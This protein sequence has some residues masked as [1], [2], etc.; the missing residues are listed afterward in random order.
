MTDISVNSG[1]C[2]KCN[3]YFKLKLSRFKTVSEVCVIIKFVH[4]K[5]QC[6]CNAVKVC[7][8]TNLSKIL[9][10]YL[11]LKSR[12]CLGRRRFVTVCDV[13][14][15]KS[16]KNCLTYFMDGPLIYISLVLII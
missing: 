14:G 3:S 11:N 5:F 7:L 15:S 10:I 4:S 12:R 8:K 6:F 16:A 13:E 1:E 2:V 9:L